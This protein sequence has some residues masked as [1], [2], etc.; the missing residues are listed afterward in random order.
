M[1][2]EKTRKIIVLSNHIQEKHGSQGPEKHQHAQEGDVQQIQ[3]ALT[4]NG[5]TLHSADV[6]AE[7]CAA[8]D[9]IGLENSSKDESNLWAWEDSGNESGSEHEELEVSN[10][11]NDSESIPTFCNI[12]EEM[13]DNS[14]DEDEDDSETLNIDNAEACTL[15]NLFDYPHFD[16][17]LPNPTPNSPISFASVMEFW[18]D[19]KTALNAERTRQETLSSE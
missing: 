11:G 6:E 12:V 8:L 3:L 9:S 5:S 10:V 4:P 18:K 17:F 16:E 2:T 1:H 19:I 15:A 13:M 7:I 14:E